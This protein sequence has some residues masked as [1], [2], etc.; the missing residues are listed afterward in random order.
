MIVTLLIRIVTDLIL[1]SVATSGRSFEQE[2]SRYFEQRGYP[3]A[4]REQ[5]TAR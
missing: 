2:M 3:A 5:A 1:D 4:S